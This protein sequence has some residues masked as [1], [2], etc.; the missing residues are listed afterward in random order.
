MTDLY[1]YF[2]TY[3][4]Y[5]KKTGLYPT[6]HTI[7]GP[8]SFPEIIIEGKRFLTFSSN[9]YLGLAGN[10]LVKAA[11]IEGIKK[12]GV[13]SGSTRLLSG[14]LDVQVEFES[15]LA[16]YLER[17]TSITFSSGYLANA[18]VIRMLVDPFP[19]FTF[20][21]EESGVIISDALNHASII[22]GV[23]LSRAERAVFRHKDMN[24]LEDLLKH[25]PK[26]RKLIITDGVFSMDGDIAPLK[27]IAELGEQYDAFTM[28]DDAHG[29]GVVGPK[30]RGTAHMLGVQDKI[31]VV[32]GSFTKAFGSIGGFIGV[33]SILDEY[34]RITT[35]SY[36]FSDPI[37]PAVVVGLMETLRIIEE[38]DNLREKVLHNAEYLRSELRA[39]GY[40]VLGHDT[41]IVPVFIGSEEKAIRFADELY[42][43]GILAPCIRR[44]AVE[45]GGER[46]R[47]SVMATHEKKHLDALLERFVVLG[48]KLGLITG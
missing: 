40:T 42:K 14:T 9:N 26:K 33:N 34:L 47:I 32:M 20:S 44:P 25:Y 45:E 28:I 10:D 39:L 16:K 31:S 5:L 30:G 8:S 13:G 22:D 4:A 41:S 19:Y 18:G 35:R 1:K 38:G 15:R 46:I 29:T 12:Y 7:V 23:R 2:N 24:H 17:D 21:S 37:I 36:I 48:K 3:L 6:L 27:E 43:S 11:T